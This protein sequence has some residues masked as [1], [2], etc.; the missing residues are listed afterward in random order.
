MAYRSNLEKTV[1]GI[2]SPVFD[3]E[4]LELDYTSEHKYTP[5]FT[6]MDGLTIEVKGRMRS[7]AEAAKYIDIRKCNPGLRLVFIFQ[8]DCTPMP[9][10]KRRKDGSRFTMQEWADKHGFEW[11]TPFTIPKDWKK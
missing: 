6:R 11:Y 5:D 10:A 8:N 1:A 7:S 4:L 2:L 3:Y 9:N